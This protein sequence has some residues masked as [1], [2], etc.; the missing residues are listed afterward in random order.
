MYI[1][2]QQCET[3]KLKKFHAKCHDSV[4]RHKQTGL[5]HLAM[6]TRYK[7]GSKINHLNYYHY[8]SNINDPKPNKT[9]ALRV[10]N[11]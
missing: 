7:N 6:K 3:G 8:A 2:S 11:R 1:S 4:V 10:T 9:I 5:S